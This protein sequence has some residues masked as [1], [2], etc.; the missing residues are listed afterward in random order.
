MPGPTFIITTVADSWMILRVLQSW[1]L[2]NPHNGNAP[3]VRKLADALEQKI[4]VA[5]GDITK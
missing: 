4:A 1:L 5:R 3:E 2:Q